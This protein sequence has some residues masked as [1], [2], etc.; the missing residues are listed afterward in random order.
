[1]ASLDDK[2]NNELD[3]LNDMLDN[4]LNDITSGQA[5]VRPAIQNSIKQ[6]NTESV[7]FIGDA[8]Q[9]RST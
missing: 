2:L 7:Q 8:A 9:E 1:M 4:E 5:A 3:E 6:S